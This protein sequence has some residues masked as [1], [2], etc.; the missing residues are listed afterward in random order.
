MSESINMEILFRQIDLRIIELLQME[1]T[2]NYKEVEY[3][4]DELIRL[5]GVSMAHMND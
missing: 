4:I 1:K 3:R 2:E 5:K